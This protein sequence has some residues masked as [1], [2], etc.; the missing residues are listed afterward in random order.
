MWCRHLNWIEDVWRRKMC[1]EEWKK[2]LCGPWQ[3]SYLQSPAK[4]RG[5]A[6][7]DVWRQEL[8]GEEKLLER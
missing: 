7:H 2:G 3:D 5:N 1:G 8:V 6:H 4:T